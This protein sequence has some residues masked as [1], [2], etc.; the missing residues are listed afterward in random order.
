MPIWG[1]KESTHLGASPTQPKRI[2]KETTARNASM[3]SGEYGGSESD[4]TLAMSTI[5]LGR[6][7]EMLGEDAN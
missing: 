3:H 4:V 7:V 6:K 2:K 1:S 5:P